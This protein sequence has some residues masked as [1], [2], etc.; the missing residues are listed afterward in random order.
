MHAGWGRQL[1]NPGCSCS[2]TPFNATKAG[3]VHQQLEY[4][5]ELAT[6]QRGRAAQHHPT[7]GRLPP[8]SFCDNHFSRTKLFLS[9]AWYWR[10]EGEQTRNVQ[11]DR[12]TNR[13]VGWKAANGKASNWVTWQPWQDIDARTQSRE[14]GLFT[15]FVFLDS[16]RVQ[17]FLNFNND[18]LI[19]PSVVFLVMLVLEKL[20]FLLSYPQQCLIFCFDPPCVVCCSSFSLGASGYHRA[21]FGLQ[22]FLK[23]F[24]FFPPWWPPSPQISIGMWVLHCIEDPLWSHKRTLLDVGG[25]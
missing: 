3:Q 10:R 19:R 17:A 22:T 7:W 8:F 21:S 1:A 25:Y 12:K 16:S 24:F 18:N 11:E 5:R 14:S 9:S 20:L 6:W 2:D 13:A 15:T 4:I 23:V